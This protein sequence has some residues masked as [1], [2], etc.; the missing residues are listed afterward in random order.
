MMSEFN[1]RQLRFVIMPTRFV[2]EKYQRDLNAAYGSWKEVWEFT[3]QQEMNL[4]EILYSDNFT[5]QSHLAVLFHGKEPMVVITMNYFDLTSRMDLDD[6]YFKVW[7]ENI[8]S[9]LKKTSKKIM[10]CGNLALN[11]NFRKGSIGVSGKDLIFALLVQFL[12]YNQL[13][14]MVATVRPEK[15]VQ[16][17]AYRTGA[18]CLAEGLPF[19][20]PGRMIDIVCWP[21]NLDDK[22]MDHELY[23]LV[24]YIWLN[25][26]EIVERHL[27]QGVKHVA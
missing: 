7:P 10:T 3:Y 24:Q 26:T 13:D 9:E 19:T 27:K 14:S 25:S 23:Q 15:G 5:R 4:Q 2:P 11:F 6:S 1:K 18:H 12:K 22:K 21:S 17:A 16:R 8:L 20:I